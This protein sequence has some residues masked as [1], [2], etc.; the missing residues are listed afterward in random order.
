[1]PKKGENNNNNNKL[2]LNFNLVSEVHKLNYMFFQTSMKFHSNKWHIEWNSVSLMRFLTYFLFQ[3]VCCYI[4]C[5]S[6]ISQDLQR[7][8]YSADLLSSSHF[9]RQKSSSIA[10]MRLLKVYNL[11]SDYT[12]LT[13]RNVF[14]LEVITVHHSTSHYI[15]CKKCNER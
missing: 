1:M 3:D 11:Q 5:R 7:C 2:C 12:L 15:T 4:H 9:M 13:V 10:I 6:N 8:L 14:A